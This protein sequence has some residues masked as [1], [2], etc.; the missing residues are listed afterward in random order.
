MEIN[1]ALNIMSSDFKLWERATD[2]PTG[3]GKIRKTLNLPWG[4][5]EYVVDLEGMNDASKRRAAVSS[6]GELIRRV[7]KERTDDTNVTSRAQTAAADAE[8]VDS[9][10]SDRVGGGQP[11]RGQEIQ[12]A[13][14]EDTD[15]AYQEDAESNVGWRETLIA[16]RA[17]IISRL[18]GLTAIADAGLLEVKGIDAALEATK[19]E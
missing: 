2:E 17:S 4:I 1:E 8:Q 7:I 14:Y 12:E 15:E 10:N 6:Y 13:A 11:V 9:D 19:D 5:G 3:A 16:R 18:E